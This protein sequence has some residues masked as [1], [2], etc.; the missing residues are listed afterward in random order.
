MPA[1]EPTDLDL[2]DPHVIELDLQVGAVLRDQAPKT[3]IYVP[4]FELDYGLTERV[5]LDVDGAVSLDETETGFVPTLDTL[6]T[7][8]KLE[9]WALRDDRDERRAWSLGTQL[10]PRWP[11]APHAYG[12]GFGAVLLAARTDPPVHV[13]LNGGFVA[14]PLDH[15]EPR[16]SAGMLGG[17]DLDYDLDRRERF[18]LL[19][20]LAGAYSLGPDPDD[21]HA[22]LG[23]EYSVAAW[24]DLTIV[25]FYG[26]LAGGDRAGVFL[27][28]TPKW[29]IAGR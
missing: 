3:R 28:L 2:E 1:F 25:G 15:T 23:L 16:R 27:G 9:L 18:S 11:T 22:T 21:V 7:C 13:I 29:A 19:G 8:V 26:F 5:E 17:F 10:G 20:E 24:F 14:E 6:W 12:S 4:D